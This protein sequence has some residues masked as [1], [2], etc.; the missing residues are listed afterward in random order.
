MGTEET[1][2]VIERESDI[3]KMITEGL[4]NIRAS[5]FKNNFEYIS[6][7]KRLRF[8]ILYSVLN[9]NVY[10]LKKKLLKKYKD[11]LNIRRKVYEHREGLYSDCQ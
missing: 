2:H 9:D 7:D 4:P 10:I 11:A 6:I 3:D 1:I 5:F 8:C